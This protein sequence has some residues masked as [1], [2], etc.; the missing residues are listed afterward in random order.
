MKYQS[1]ILAAVA[2]AALAM[3][4]HAQDVSGF[5][6]EARAGWDRSSIDATLPN[7]DYDEEDEDSGP[8]FLTGSEKDSSIAYGFEAGYDVML[9]SSF[10]LGAYAGA[11]LSDAAICGEVV[12]DDLACADFGRTFT[13]GA[14]VGVPI[15][16]TSLFYV[17]GGYSNGKLSATYDA[18]VTDNDDETPGAIAS[19]SHTKGGYHLGAGLELGLTQALYAKVEYVYTNF[20][21]RS[22]LVGDDAATDP[23]LVVGSDRHQALVGLGLR[24]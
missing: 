19:F 5:R 13:L 11:E 8:E 24:F 18:D 22:W 4:A 10:V 6:I 9:G 16:E 14:R 1:L 7:P 12:E 23:T 3:P 2:A 20:G 21:N 15:G 17:K